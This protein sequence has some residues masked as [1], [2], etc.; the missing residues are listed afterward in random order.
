METRRVAIDMDALV[1]AIRNSRQSGGTSWYLDVE[2]GRVLGV[3]SNL[4]SSLENSDDLDGITRYDREQLQQAEQILYNPDRYIPVEGLSTEDLNRMMSEFL[5]TV[6][7][8]ELRQL[9]QSSAQGKGAYRRFRET[10]ARYPQEMQRWVEFEKKAVLEFAQDWLDLNGIE[11]EAL[12]QGW[13]SE[14]EQPVADSRF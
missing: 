4:L 7:D 12:A 9:L 3:D 10:L 14:R 2:T 11:V 1:Q 8:A 6:G 13:Q 5:E